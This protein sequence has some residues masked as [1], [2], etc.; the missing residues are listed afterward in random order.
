MVST[1]SKMYTP[2][3]TFTSSN[4]L[5]SKEAAQRK[6]ENRKPPSKP[7][8][9]AVSKKLSEVSTAQEEIAILSKTPLKPHVPSKMKSVPIPAELPTKSDH[10]SCKVTTN[11]LP[12]KWMSLPGRAVNRSPS[13]KSPSS[14]ISKKA[15]ST[16]S[17]STPPQSTPPPR[18]FPRREPPPPPTLADQTKE[19][20]IQGLHKQPMSSN[21]PSSSQSI[22][23]TPKTIPGSS[24]LRT[25]N[26]TLKSVLKSATTKLSASDNIFLTSNLTNKSV[27]QAEYEDIDHDHLAHPFRSKSSVI[28]RNCSMKSLTFGSSRDRFGHKGSREVSEL[29]KGASSHVSD[30]SD[31]QDDTK[32]CSELEN[33]QDGKLVP[34]SSM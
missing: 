10:S 2:S 19:L 3:S 18:Y 17:V 12:A 11:S 13:Y 5:S 34:Y 33:G 20:Q 32:S 6:R 26:S 9:Y 29:D 30:A 7:L 28:S 24:S 1:R 14:H 21:A 8:P 25:K 22:P 31:D 27:E 15:R 16:V 4:V 23:S